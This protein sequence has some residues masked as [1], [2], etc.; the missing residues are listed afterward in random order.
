MTLSPYSFEGQRSNRCWPGP[1]GLGAALTFVLTGVWRGC[2]RSG[3]RPDLR[4]CRQR[5]GQGEAG[6]SL[7][8]IA[9]VVVWFELS[10]TRNTGSWDRVSGKKKQDFTQHLQD[11]GAVSA[12]EQGHLGGGGGS[13]A[14]GNEWPL[15]LLSGTRR[16]RSGQREGAV[17]RGEQREGHVSISS[18]DKIRNT[19]CELR[20]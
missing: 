20:F 12:A 8:K 15:R 1:W 2:G 4:V 10:D 9:F 11:F 17:L 7:S 16:D 5:Q 13:P 6:R 18:S 19:Y 14:P 3:P